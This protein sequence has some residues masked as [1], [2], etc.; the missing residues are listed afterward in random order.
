MAYASNA[1]RVGAPELCNST[2]IIGICDHFIFPRRENDEFLEIVEPDS[3][4]MQTK[5]A[6]GRLTQVINC[7]D[8]EGRLLLVDSIAMNLLVSKLSKEFDGLLPWSL[9]GCYSER[10]SLNACNSKLLSWEFIQS[11]RNVLLWKA[12]F[13]PVF[14]F[15][16]CC[17]CYPQVYNYFIG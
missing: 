5:L 7:L 14:T 2:F 11:Y 9:L 13:Y 4:H 16:W 6:M 12:Y 10:C 17:N 8:I 15:V 1:D 3:A